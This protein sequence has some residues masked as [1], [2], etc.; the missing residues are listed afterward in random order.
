MARKA[1]QALVGAFVLGA[2]LLA[3]AGVVILGGGHFLRRTETVVAYFDGSLKGLDIG[4][5][6]TF[7]GVKIGSVVDIGVV[8]DRR[9]ASIRTPVV[10]N[11]DF[12][13]LHLAEGGKVKTRGDLPK[14]E[15]WIEHGLRAR[16]ALQSFV[17][18]QL[19]VELNFHPHTPVRLT[20]LAKDY[21]E[22]PTIPSQFD[23]L[24]RTLENLPIEALV[25]EATETLRSIRAVASAPEVK[26]SLVKL[27]RALSGVD[28][29]VRHVDSKID[30]LSASLDQVAVE[31]RTTMAQAQEAL[32]R[33]TPAATATLADYQALA[34]DTRRFVANADAQLEILSTSVQ[35]ALADT[36]GVLGED[37]ALR[38]DL[39]NTLQEMT[40]TAKSLRTF[41]DYLERHPEALLSGKRRDADR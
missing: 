34:Q 9:D 19:A 3:V 14:S 13:R 29:L 26:S 16:L 33:L 23:H 41:A 38:Y 10:F 32:A 17:T 20:G 1:N 27:D 24:T 39:A 12:R 28:G 36:H 6:V 31:T 18:G 30:P 7:N 35:Q 5:P 22:V 40:K 2:L 8:I 21:V 11:I 4:S 37:S 25:A 15:L